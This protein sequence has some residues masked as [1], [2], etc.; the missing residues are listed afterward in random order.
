M[1]KALCSVG[2]LIFHTSQSSNLCK[3]V[4][5][6]SVWPIPWECFEMILKYLKNKVASINMET[7]SI[8]IKSSYFQLTALN[9]TQ[10]PGDL[11]G[12]EVEHFDVSTGVFLLFWSCFLSVLLILCINWADSERD[13]SEGWTVS[14]SRNSFFPPAK[15]TLAP[16]IPLGPVGG[17]HDNRT[18]KELIHQ[19]PNFS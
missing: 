1:R 10:W 6:T 9:L 11:G 3:V 4:I 8:F 18:G 15:F 12:V 16:W 14:P 13:D 5:I 2:S 17:P 19:V 7:T